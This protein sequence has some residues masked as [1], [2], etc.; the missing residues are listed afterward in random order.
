M[1]QTSS[2]VRAA[3]RQRADMNRYLASIRL[4]PS[5]LQETRVIA[6]KHHLHTFIETIGEATV[7][8]KCECGAGH[9]VFRNI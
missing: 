4:T 1:L 2:A 3:Q 9:G 7:L 8:F 6:R 5:E